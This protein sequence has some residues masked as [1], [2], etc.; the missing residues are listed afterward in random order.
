MDSPLE[1]DGFEPLVPQREGIGLF[2]TT[3]I[4]LDAIPAQAAS[5]TVCTEDAKGKDPKTTV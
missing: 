3:L 5:R 1:G 4:D 2:E